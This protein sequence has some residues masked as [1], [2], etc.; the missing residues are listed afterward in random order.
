MGQL[1]IQSNMDLFISRYVYIDIL[2]FDFVFVFFSFCFFHS[3]LFFSSVLHA[4]SSF[5]IPDNHNETG[6]EHSL[7]T[8][9]LT[10]FK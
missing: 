10:L 5:S 9:G 7:V 8:I 1:F 6:S 3:S 2:F 4:T